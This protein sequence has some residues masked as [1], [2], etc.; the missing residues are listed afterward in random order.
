[1][2][3]TLARN[4]WAL[5]LRGLLAVIFGILAWIWPDLTL[6]VLV[7][8][9]GAYALVD[10]VFAL[11]AAARGERQGS[12]WPLVIEG[13]AGVLAG[14][15]T[16][17]WPDLTARVLLYLIAAW[18]IVTG[19]IE[20]VATIHLRRE[21]ENEVLLGLGGLASVLFGVLLIIFPGSGALALVWLI[22]AYAIIF[23][24]LLIALA[25]RLRGLAQHLPTDRAAA[26]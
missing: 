6:R 16:L 3:A 17:V 18:A 11:V 10:G 4:W 7:I 9:F 26:A 25:F 24:V 8:F 20:I 21:I 14:L 12:R 5:A 23:G 22:G 1:M 2:L 15:A 13:V 19:V